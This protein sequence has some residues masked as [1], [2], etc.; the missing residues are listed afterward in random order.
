MKYLKLFE[1]F[2]EDISEELDNWI[3]DNSDY[4]SSSALE[5]KVK[6]LLSLDQ[7]I[8]SSESVEKDRGGDM[9][10][11]N[12]N[13]ILITIKY[14]GKDLIKVWVNSDYRYSSGKNV[15]SFEELPNDK[16]VRLP[17]GDTRFYFDRSLL[18]N[19]QI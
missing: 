13:K 5:D 3:E 9:Y 8:T 19:N 17:Y 1:S 16:V 7:E 14:N 6:E 4:I 2:N 18:K 15:I 11:E 10:S 12:W